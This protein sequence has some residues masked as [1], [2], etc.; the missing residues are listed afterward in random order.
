MTGRVRS[1]SEN[2]LITEFFWNS[3]RMLTEFLW[4]YRKWQE[5]LDQSSDQKISWPQN[6]SGN[7]EYGFILPLCSQNNM[8]SYFIYML[9]MEY[10]FIFCLY[11]QNGIWIHILFR[12]HSLMTSHIRIGRGSKIA[13]QKERYR[14]GQG[15]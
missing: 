1:K 11:T 13:P 12:E 7:M 2:Q 15:R 8:D 14:V 5:K 9:K 10:G 6:S 4:S 3:K